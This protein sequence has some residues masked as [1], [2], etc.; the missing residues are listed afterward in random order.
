MKIRT[1]LLTLC[2]A[3]FAGASLAQ[4]TEMLHTTPDNPA[5]DNYTGGLGC[6]F[7]VG[8]SNVIVSHLGVFDLNDD[9]L[10]IDH[11]AGIFNGSGSV[12]LDTVVVPAG[13]GGYLTNGFRWAPLDPPVL[14]NAN[15]TY[16]VAG[17]VVTSDGDPWQD[18][19]SP[20]W[21]PVF[22]GTNA[23]TTRHAMYGPG[24]T[25][26]W[27]PPSFSQNGNNNTYGNVS[28]AY[29]EIDRARVGV[30]TTNVALSAGQTLSVVGFASGQRPITY[31]WFKAPGTLLADQTNATLVIPNSSTN[32]SG[33][34]FLTATNALGGAQS[35][36]VSV[37]VTSF[38]VGITQHPTNLTVFA[39]Y[40]ATFSLSATGSPPISFQWF[41]NGEPI[42]GATTTTY[43]I[44]SAS[45]TNNGD[46]YF[47]VASNF[48]SGTSFTQTSSN[49]T[50]TVI[51]NVAFPQRFL[52]GYNTNLSQNNFSGMVGG[53]I[54]VGSAPV[55]VTHLGYYAPTNQYTDATHCNLT[56]SHRVGLF[57]AN[58]TVLY[59]YVTVP[60]GVGEVLNGYLWAP[61]DPPLVLTNGVQYVLA[62]ETFAGVD[63]WGNTYAIPDLNA[64][65]AVNCAATFWGAAWPGGGVS[66][67]FSG[68]MYSA[69]NLAILALPTPTAYVRP[70]NVTQ[71]AGFDVTLNAIAAGAP[72][73]TLQWFKQPGNPLPGQTHTAL[74]FP[75]VSLSDAGAYFVIATNNVTGAFAQSA[76]AVVNVLPD[77]GPSLDQDVQSQSAFIHQTVRFTAAA[78][79]TPTL[80]Y[81]WWFN[82]S[83]LPGATNSTLTLTNVSEANAGNYQL[84]ITN[85]WGATNSS[86]A[87]L[88]VLVPAWGSYPASVMLGTDL[89]AYYRF[90]DVSSGLGIATNQGSLGLAING[91][92]E[93]TA[94]A[95]GPTNMSHFEAGNQA[96][97]LD[98]LFA[99][100]RIPTLGVSVNNATIAAWIYKSA[101]QVPDAAIYWHRGG[102]VFGLSSSPDPATGGDALRYTWNGTYFSFVSGLVFP[103]NE[104][105]LVAVSVT[106]TNASLYLRDS[107]GLRSTNNAASHPA[108]SFSVTNYIGWDTAGGALGRRWN[109]LID[110]VMIFNRALSATEINAL[111][112]GVPTSAVLTIAPDGNNLRLT[113]P[114]GKLLEADDI[115]GPWTTNNA[116]TSPFLVTPSAARKF[117]RVQLQP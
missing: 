76:D 63:P 31:Q 59:G 3:G 86:I 21:N 68:Q 67:L 102:N 109:G 19:F 99:D 37:S 8:S 28:L 14:L 24:G 27:P 106:S 26:A 94:A 41:R 16:L 91:V 13:T 104:W 40:P 80:A 77:V 50:L 29:I 74:S 64:Y 107:A 58:G 32:D 7:R 110:E 11:N 85:N 84:T 65:F 48:T 10:A 62:A 4:V 98:G 25:T 71:Y 57:N 101:D 30:Q 56:Q 92:Y 52:H 5:R 42:P 88:S 79:G 96:V 82:G 38:P 43:S 113:W 100:V 97:S 75:N 23:G 33:V 47:G 87:A 46:T 35:A 53:R 95:D 6:Q 116:A 73:V 108:Q 90:S 61:L 12:L 20:T 93:N 36:N 51:P 70:T 112:F 1:L 78:S 72:P 15:T 103:T 44:A 2:M 22:V 17:S 115:N 39:N 45:L 105:A 111:Y 54:T 60:A 34:Y 49:V 83:P 117:Y 69:P 114:G 66:G 9:G 55:V 18:A 81:Q 89:L